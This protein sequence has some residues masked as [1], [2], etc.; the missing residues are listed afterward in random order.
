MAQQHATLASGFGLI[1]WDSYLVF[2]NTIQGKLFKTLQPDT[3]D[4]S[5]RHDCSS[6]LS[7][8]NYV[9]IMVSACLEGVE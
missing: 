5:E 6:E 7:L 1:T 2:P 8:L 9:I 4:R 3:S